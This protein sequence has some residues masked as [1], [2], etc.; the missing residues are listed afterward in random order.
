VAPRKVMTDRGVC[1]VGTETAAL[2]ADRFGERRTAGLAGGERALHRWLIE[3][4]ARDGRVSTVQLRA[5]ARRC[6]VDFERT[7]AH[8][9]R[10][11]LVHLGDDAIAA[12]YPF[13][14]R[15]TRHRVWI[16]GRAEPV[17]AMCALD[18]LGIA[19]MLNL[20]VEILSRDPA[21]G[22]EVWV[23]FDPG[24]G[25]WWEPETAVVLDGRTAP[26]GP[27]FQTCC[28]AINFFASGENALAYLV[29]HPGLSG[30][31]LTLPEAIDAGAA[32]FGE[33]LEEAS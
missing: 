9:A 2:A 1:C 8:F 10:R 7:L 11:D 13:S 19:P 22:G 5:A 24:D 4:F 29:A 27:S 32:I 6:D 18:A 14:G 15:P 17:F 3:S 16:D 25:A 20:P 31:P 26:G 28:G 30:H 21:S 12:V 33:M 23:R